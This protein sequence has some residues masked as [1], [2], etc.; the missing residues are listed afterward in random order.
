M[1]GIFQPSHGFC[2]ADNAGNCDSHHQLVR[3]QPWEL[4][5]D[6]DRNEHQPSH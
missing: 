1:L 3:R 5:N 4:F 2:H 6:S